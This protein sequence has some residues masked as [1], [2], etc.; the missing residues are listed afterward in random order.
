MLHILR[1]EKKSTAKQ[2]I[3]TSLSLIKRIR[4]RQT[5]LFFGRVIRKET[6][7]IGTSADFKNDGWKTTQRRTERNNDRGNGTVLLQNAKC[8]RIEEVTNG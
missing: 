5:T 4:K 8:E 1:R 7:K 3:R 2:G 6:N